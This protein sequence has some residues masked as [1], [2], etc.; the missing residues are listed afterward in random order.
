MAR[1]HVVTVLPSQATSF[2]FFTV[3]EPLGSFVNDRSHGIL[4]RVGEMTP[5]VPLSVVVNERRYDYRSV[6]HPGLTPFLAA[7]VTQSSQ[8]SRGQLFGDQTIAVKIELS[9]A[10]QRPVAYTETISGGEAS[11]QASALVAAVV[12]YLEN[13]TFEVPNLEAVVVEITAEERV[14]TARLVDVVP[15]RRV[16]RPGEALSVRLRFR[17]YQGEEFTRELTIDVPPGTP[18][19]R[20]DLVVADGASWTLY[21]LGMRPFRPGSFGDELRLIRRLRPSTSLV[22]AL[23]RK[24][25]GVTLS[26]GS[27]AMPPGLVAQ[28]R[29]GL[30]PGLETTDYAVVAT[31]EEGMGLPLAGAERIELRVRSERPLGHSEVQ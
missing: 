19:G 15:T 31:V 10:G 6:R 21:D 25:A 5:M 16:V 30:G 3:G 29:G 11:A 20:L 28:L 18:E 7:S 26:G 9:Y 17:P 14:R 1:T 24:Q 27:V 13:S 12:A 22:M 4:G 23:E 8:A 2:K